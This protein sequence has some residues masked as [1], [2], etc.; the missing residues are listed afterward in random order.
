M[1][2]SFHFTD[3]EAKAHIEK[4]AHTRSSNKWPRFEPTQFGSSAG[5][6][7]SL[8]CYLNGLLSVIDYGNFGGNTWS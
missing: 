4:G 3:D 2:S 5:T 8:D 6:L 1:S 7:D